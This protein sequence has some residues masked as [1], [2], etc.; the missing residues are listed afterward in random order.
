VVVVAARSDWAKMDRPQALEALGK[1]L[2]AKFLPLSQVQV[3]APSL[4]F[5]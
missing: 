1:I 4:A 2:M 5:K 3:S